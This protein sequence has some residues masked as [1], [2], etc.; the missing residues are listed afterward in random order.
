MKFLAVLQ[1]RADKQD[2]SF[3]D[4]GIAGW[5]APFNPNTPPHSHSELL[6][7]EGMCFSSASR[8]DHSHGTRWIDF[9]LLTTNK[10]RWD[11]YYKEV[12]EDYDRA[13]HERASDIVGRPYYY[14]GLFL[15][16]FLPL[17]TIGHL[18]GDFT[19]HWY[20]SQSVWYCLQGERKRVSPRRLTKW[21]LREGFK[22]I[23]MAELKIILGA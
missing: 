6:F 12:D 19:N 10:D 4:D 11:V 23:T 5:T 7:S 8:G 2:G 3:L 20:C 13:C 15:D 9:E 1:Y 14:L 18:V 21:I 22:K 17:D 16:F